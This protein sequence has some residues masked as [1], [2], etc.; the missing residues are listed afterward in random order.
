MRWEERSEVYSCQSSVASFQ[1]TAIPL[2]LLPQTG[3][4]SLDLG[5]SVSQTFVLG[6]LDQAQ[7]PRQQQVVFDLAGR[8]HRDRAEPG[9]LTRCRCDRI[10][11]RDWRQLRNMNFEVDCSGRTALRAETRPLSDRR[12]RS[13]YG[14]SAR[15]SVRGNLALPVSRSPSY[16]DPAAT[17]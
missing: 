3:Q 12:P 17:S 9:Q 10:L 16:R 11:Q 8:S 13:I 1:L 2:Q 5:G 15:P 4:H 14:P 6:W 7:I